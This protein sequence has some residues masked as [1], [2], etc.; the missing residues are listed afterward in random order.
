MRATTAEV[1]LS[2]AAGLSSSSACAAPPDAQ[3]FSTSND[4]RGALNTLDLIENIQCALLNL[5]NTEVQQQLKINSLLP[6]LSQTFPA[7]KYQ[8]V[9]AGANSDGLRNDFPNTYGLVMLYMVVLINHQKLNLHSF[10]ARTSSS[11]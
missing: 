10:S 6:Q 5:C 7:G 3:N 8:L 2:G 9:F 1:L 4:V 11:R